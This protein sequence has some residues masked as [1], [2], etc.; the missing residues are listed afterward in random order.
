MKLA[1]HTKVIN[2]NRHSDNWLVLSHACKPYDVNSNSTLLAYSHLSEECHCSSKPSRRDMIPIQFLR[3]NALIKQNESQRIKDRIFSVTFL[4]SV[5]LY[6]ISPEAVNAQSLRQ[7]Q[8]PLKI[9][10]KKVKVTDDDV[11]QAA[12]LC[13]IKEGR[14]VNGS[15]INV[16]PSPAQ[17]VIMT[18]MCP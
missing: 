16:R 5:M 14:L 6:G 11:E 3:K 7:N 17:I 9:T 18:T 1:N 4:F 2:I 10:V 15:T 13:L 12:K 8:I